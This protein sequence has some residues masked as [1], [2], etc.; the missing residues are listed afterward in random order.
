M[1]TVD[2]DF[3]PEV[4][5]L[6]GCLGDT[7]IFEESTGAFLLWYDSPGGTLPVASGSSC[8]VNDIQTDTNLWIEGFGLDELRHTGKPDNSGGGSNF[9][10]AYVHYLVFDVMKPVRLVSVLLYAG[11]AGNKSFRILDE[12]DIEIAAFNPS[13]PVGESRVYLNVEIPAGNNYRIECQE[14]PNLYRNNTGVSYPYKIDNLISI[15]YSSAGN[16]PTDPTSLSYYY[17]FYDWEVI[18]SSCIT[19]RIP[20]TASISQPV[21]VDFTYATNIS[22]VQFTSTT[23]QATNYLWDFGD[24]QTSVEQNPA[25][26]YT[27]A[28]TYQVILTASNGCYSESKQ[29]SITI[30]IGITEQE[31]NFFS[32]YPNPAT[33]AI[34]LEFNQYTTEE[35]SIY[36]IDAQGRIIIQKN[37]IPNGL[38]QYILLLDEIAS[39]IYNIRVSSKHDLYNKKVM[40]QKD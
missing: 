7:L 32:A 23:S 10:S 34:T 21:T 38:K 28:G 35:F 18:E 8:A 1:V 3:L 20:V 39:G 5:A 36:L 12:N 19:E 37:N 31:D 4:P 2:M 24:G 22:L 9:N 27:T 16:G 15:N 33:D 30:T 13:V 29:Q 40:I 26:N 11:G 17:F 6:D 25:H 14:S